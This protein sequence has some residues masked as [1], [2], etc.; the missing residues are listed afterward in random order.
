MTVDCNYFD[1]IESD[2]NNK[3]NDYRFYNMLTELNVTTNKND[4]RL[5]NTFDQIQC[6]NIQHDCR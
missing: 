6:D 4:Y 3:Q 5:Y 1:N 2:N